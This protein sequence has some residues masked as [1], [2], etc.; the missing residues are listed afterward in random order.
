MLI[1]Y[2]EFLRR[3][4]PAIRIER[5]R[6]GHESAQYLPALGRAN[7]ERDALLV[8]VEGLKIVAVVTRKGERGNG[9][10]GIAAHG[11]ILYLD[12]L[13]PHIRQ[14]LRGQRPRPELLDRQYPQPFQRKSTIH[15]SHPFRNLRPGIYL[16]TRGESILQGLRFTR[17]SSNINAFRLCII[18]LHI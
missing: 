15:Q 8:A 3:R 18:H 17:I 12:D 16:T 11:V 5:I 2:F 7:P 10:R 14:Q 13:G 1:R 9:P 6:L 4:A